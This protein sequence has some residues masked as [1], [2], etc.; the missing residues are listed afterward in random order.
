M[1]NRH[2]FTLIELLVVIAII[3]ILASMLLPALNSAR[4]R[5][6]SASCAGKLRSIGQGMAL[7]AG[8]YQDRLPDNASNTSQFWMGQVKPYLG[9]DSKTSGKASFIDFQCPSV[10]NPQYSTYAL[11]IWFNAMGSKSRAKI[12]RIP[13]PSRMI[14]VHDSK[15]GAGQS[16]Y[17]S[18]LNW[19]T[20]NHQQKANV[21]MVAGNVVNIHNQ[22]RE[23]RF[24]NC[25]RW[26]TWYWAENGSV[27]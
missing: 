8:D 20:L 6:K 26:C 7:Y 15:D 13:L 18:M 21:V 2:D 10:V 27:L 12:N 25:Q 5:A 9:K 22:D 19:F 16:S 1:K 17:T 3:A 11:N 4:E 23:V 14:M 24:Q